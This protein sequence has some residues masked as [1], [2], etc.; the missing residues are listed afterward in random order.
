MVVRQRVEKLMLSNVAELYVGKEY[1][2]KV[3]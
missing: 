1:T 2:V 3:I